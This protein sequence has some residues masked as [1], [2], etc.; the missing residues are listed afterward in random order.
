MEELDEEDEEGTGEEK[1][2]DER[3]IPRQVITIA[4]LTA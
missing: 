1:E 3:A 2:E 4:V